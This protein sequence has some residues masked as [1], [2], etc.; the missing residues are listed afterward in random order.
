[1]EKFFIV[2]LFVIAFIN[3]LISLWLITK[4]RKKDTQIDQDISMMRQTISTQEKEVANNI[5]DIDL[6]IR[7]ILETI[8][9]QENKVIASFN[10]AAS[11]ANSINKKLDEAIEDI[12]SKIKILN[13]IIEELKKENVDKS[14]VHSTAIVKIEKKLESI[15]SDYNEL[16]WQIE[17]LTE[18]EADSK[19]LNDSLDES[20]QEALIEAIV[21]K[22]STS[23]ETYNIEEKDGDSPQGADEN[24][25]GEGFG[26]FNKPDANK[27]VPKKEIS[28]VE[29]KS[30][31]ESNLEQQR[32]FVE[33]DSNINNIPIDNSY[34]EGVSLDEEQAKALDY[35]ENTAN[36]Y[37]I[38]GKAGTGKSFCL[39]F[40]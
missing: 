18:I 6:K 25:F 24:N 5:K 23:R 32:A 20:H 35:M 38:T 26:L 31:D 11:H 1:M 37:F 19:K 30:I 4:R 40:V 36:N 7:N 2:L 29:D 14:E 8:N 17:N 39:F 21:N 27:N 9:I 28:L 33:F 13:N 16:K 22:I 10:K 34:G 12:N 3:S 15:V